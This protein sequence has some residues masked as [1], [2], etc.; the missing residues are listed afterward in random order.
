MMKTQM[1]D[2]TRIQLL[3]IPVIIAVAIL[4]AIWA[5]SYS[6]NLPRDAAGNLLS[7]I[8]PI[9][10]NAADLGIYYV[11]RSVLFMVNITLLAFLTIKYAVLYSKAKS[12]FT[13]VLLMF[14]LLLLVKDILS[15]PMVIG[16]FSFQVAG[17]GPFALIEP[18]VELLALSFLLYLNL[19]Y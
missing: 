7:P 15:S 9:Q 5:I 10:S 3:I 4:T 8:G 6:I 18:L 16:I 19:K 17:L 2:K 14:L 13:I 1:K 12:Q 11:V